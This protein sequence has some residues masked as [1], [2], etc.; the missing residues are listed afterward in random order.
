MN[1]ELNAG[2]AAE[3]STTAEL[4]PSDSLAQNPM[5]VAVRVIN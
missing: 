1:N 5:L 2:T 4:L 3:S